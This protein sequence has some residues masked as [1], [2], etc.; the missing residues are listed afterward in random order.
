MSNEKSGGGLH[1]DSDWKTEAAREKEQLAAT[2]EAAETARTGEAMPG[3][4]GFVDLVN[5]LAMQAAIALGGYQGPGGERIP[6]NP[7]AARHQIDLMGILA[8]KTQGN[9]TEDEK[10]VLDTVLYELRMQF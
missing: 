4:A 9:L 3:Q 8:D 6:P 2:E 7:A 1:I 5:L 10:R